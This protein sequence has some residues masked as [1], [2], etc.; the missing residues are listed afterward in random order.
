M[1]ISDMTTSNYR[2]H[3]RSQLTIAYFLP[4]MRGWPVGP[5]VGSANVLG[6]REIRKRGL[7]PDYDIEWVYRDT[8]CEPKRAMQMVVDAWSSVDRLD[9]IIGPGCSVTCQ[10]LGLLAAFWN[11]PIISYDCSSPKLSD[12]SVYPTF[13]RTVGTKSAR[14][15]VYNWLVDMFNWTNIGIVSTP[16]DVYKISSADMKEEMEKYGKKVTL[17]TVDSTVKGKEV[18]KQKLEGMRNVFKTMKEY[19]RIFILMTYPLDLRNML[20]TAKDLGMMHGEYA[21]LTN[22]YALSEMDVEY[23]SYRPEIDS[24]IYN[25]IIGMGAYVPSGAKWEAFQQDVIDSLQEMEPQ[26]DGLPHLP[27]DASINEVPIYAGRL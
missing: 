12:K 4:W 1:G 19:N 6:I 23:H 16:E 3:N 5:Q 9:A 11:I 2:H 24:T 10:P 7:L 20:I 22:E 26:F 13:S 15:P 14:A 21:F 27:P 18:D 25:G 17:Q 8:W